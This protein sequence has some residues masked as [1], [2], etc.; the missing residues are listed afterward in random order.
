KKLFVITFFTLL[1]ASCASR[2]KLAYYQDIQ[3]LTSSEMKN[4]NPTLKA[5]DLLLIIVS[6]PVPETA[7]D[8]NLGTYTMSGNFNSGTQNLD[9]A[10]GQIRHQTYLIDN[11]GF[12]Q[13]PVIGSLKLGG[14]TREEAVNLLDSSLKKYVK[15]PII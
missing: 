7:K 14:L 8:F 13:F 5:D 2:E 12:I 10:Q 6:S 4:Y 3:N 15:D 11:K 9:L 1:L